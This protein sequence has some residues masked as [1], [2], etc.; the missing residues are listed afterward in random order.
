MSFNKFESASMGHRKRQQKTSDVICPTYTFT[1]VLI[2]KVMFDEYF[3]KH[4][5]YD[6]LC[7]S[8]ENHE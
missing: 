8:R 1:K 6:A 7:K 3:T 2:L 4:I 5:F